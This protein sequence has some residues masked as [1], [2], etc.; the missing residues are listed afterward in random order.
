MEDERTRGKNVKIL[1]ISPDLE[2]YEVWI[3]HK[4]CFQFNWKKFA[5]T[6]KT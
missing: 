1:F 6:P 5:L 4:D 2:K 3:E